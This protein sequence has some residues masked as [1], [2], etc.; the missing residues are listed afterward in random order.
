MKRVKYLKPRVGNRGSI[1][2]STTDVL[3]DDEAE[4]LAERGEVEILET[5]PESAKPKP[6]L[7]PE[8]ADKKQSAKAEKS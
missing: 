6:E 4:K 7:K 1:P 3:P 2:V 8:F 5:V